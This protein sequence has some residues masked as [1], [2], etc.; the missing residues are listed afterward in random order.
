MLF[1]T[2]KQRARVFSMSE[3]IAHELHAIYR[4]ILQY[5]ALL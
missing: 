1:T 4:E 5:A 2:L 3:T